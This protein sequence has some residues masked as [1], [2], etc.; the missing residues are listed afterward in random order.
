[1]TMRTNKRSGFAFFGVGM[2]T[3]TV[4]LVVLGCCS[5]NA[6][7]LPLGEATTL[8]I[9]DCGRMRQ[10]IEFYSRN[11]NRGEPKSLQLVFKGDTASACLDQVSRDLGCFGNISPLHTVPRVYKH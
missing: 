4:A 8:D 11:L 1:M 7:A 5:N 10:N 2:M 3:S 9:T 6:W